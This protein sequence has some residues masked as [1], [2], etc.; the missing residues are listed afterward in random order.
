MGIASVAQPASPAPLCGCS[1]RRLLC[2]WAA[3]GIVNIYYEDTAGSDN[4]GS[5]TWK[6]AT[7][8]W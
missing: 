1:S 3:G 7:V 5:V 8:P 2:P 6:M 4:T